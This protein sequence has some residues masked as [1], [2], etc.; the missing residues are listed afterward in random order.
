M[1]QRLTFFQPDA[2]AASLAAQ[3]AGTSLGSF[4][5]VTAYSNGSSTANVHGSSCVNGCD[6]TRGGIY[7]GLKWQCVEYI[8]RYYYSVFGLD[9]AARHR[10]DAKT[11]YDNAPKMGLQQH[12][13]EGTVAPQPGDILTSNTGRHGHVAIVR[14][15]SGNQVCVIQQNLTNDYGDANTCLSLSAAG[16]RYTVGNFPQGLTIR[17]WL[18]R[19]G[20]TPPPCT[21]GSSVAFRVNGRPP[22]HPNGTLIKLAND[23]TYYLIVNGQKRGIPTPEILHRLYQGEDGEFEFNDV[24]TV[25]QDEFDSYPTGAVINSSLPSNGRSQPD[26]K[27][28]KAQNRSEI[29]IVSDNGRR[30]PFPDAATFLNLGYLFCNVTEVADYDSYPTGPIVTGAGSNACT[31]SP[32]AL[33]ASVGGSLSDGDCNSPRRSG[34][35]ADLYTFNGTAGQRVTISLNSANFDAYLFLVGPGGNVLRE[36]DDSGGNRNS[37]ISDFTLPSSGVYTV[38]ATAYYSYGRGS[39]SIS[40]ATSSGSGG[41]ASSPIAANAS[42]GG[43]L[44]DGD[45]NSTRRADRKADLYTFSGSAGQRVTITMS[46]SSFDTYLI[47]ARTGGESLREDDDGGGGTNSRI[48]D[49]TLPSTGSYTIEAT[50]YASGGRGAYAVALATAQQ[51]QTIFLVHGIGQNSTAMQGLRNSLLDPVYGIDQARFQVDAGFDWSQCTAA[52]SCAA[53][54]TIANGGRAL[55]NHIASRD[56]QGEII[57][58]GYSLG[59]LLARDLMLN[60]YNGLFDNRRVA[61]LIT[62]GTPNVGYPFCEVDENAFC[63]TLVQQM[64]SHFR[65]RQDRNE[66]VLSEY[67][68]DLATR[69]G[70][71]SFL[72]QPRYWLAA[73]GTFC[74][75]AR[76]F[77]E[78]NALDRSVNNGCPDNNLRSDGVVCQQSAGFHI[79]VDNTPTSRWAD[80]NYAHTQVGAASLCCAAIGGP[81]I[82]SCSTRQPAEI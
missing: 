79:N 67:L 64:A 16:G 63:D 4:N 74:T 21:G 54:C 56:P 68:Y 22:V 3:P 82:T 76:R 9:L 18:R 80:A 20:A 58:I 5:G 42:V 60:N 1:A 28:I 66:V 14:S 6:T 51:R 75:D 72:G 24:V 36:D 15:V 47:L 37:R 32:I 38:E 71:S 65:L 59:G 26:G 13:N 12:P 55:A 27:L 40:V 48:A 35:K 10:G 61:A 57:L 50:A 53:T 29:S 49:F 43:S 45:C 31:P 23:R 30:Q 78:W 17:G 77:C 8:R 34:G 39:Y 7:L 70:N 25:A 44:S 2:N 52:N 46:S 81:N 41:C 33:N 19:A 11:W 73:S 69:W 62:L